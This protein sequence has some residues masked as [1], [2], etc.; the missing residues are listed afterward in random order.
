MFGNM[1]DRMQE[2]QRKTE[3]AKKRL[4]D[5]TVTGEA[6]AGAVVVEMT[7]NKKVKN[8]T[9]Q[10]NIAETDKE[11]LEDLLVIAFNKALENAENVFESEMKTVAMGLLPGI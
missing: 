5:I 11:E 4:D 3:E 2:M 7:G 9:I 6:P 8:V 10:V 1:M